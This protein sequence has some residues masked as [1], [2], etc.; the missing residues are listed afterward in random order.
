MAYTQNSTDIFEACSSDYG[1]DEL[2][3]HDKGRQ[4]Q[5]L[6]LKFKGLL[7]DF[8]YG[9]QDAEYSFQNPENMKHCWKAGTVDFKPF[10]LNWDEAMFTLQAVYA[11]YPL[12]FF[13]DLYKTGGDPAG[14]YISPII[15]TECTR[16]DFRRFYTMKIE[17][18]LKK[19]ISG[20]PDG[21]SCRAAAKKV[22]DTIKITARYDNLKGDGVKVLYVDTASHSILNYVRERSCVCQGFASTYQAIMNGLSIPTASVT[23]ITQNGAHACNIVH[24]IDEKKYIMVDSTQGVSAQ[25]DSGF[26][27][28]KG[29]YKRSPRTNACE[30]HQYMPEY[31]YIWEQYLK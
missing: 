14:G 22:Y 19:I 25:N 26:D 24:L 23:V 28:P 17:E 6:Y 1:Y 18:E 2:L 20:I 13:S 7:K 21:T 5:E 3:G 9:T 31:S 16:G 8:Y 30:Y 11:D 10:G 12:L 15:D 27:M 29:T 4:M